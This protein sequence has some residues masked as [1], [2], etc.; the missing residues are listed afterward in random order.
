VFNYFPFA[1]GVISQL[2]NHE[3]RH[4]SVCFCQQA[5]FLCLSPYVPCFG[6][7]LLLGP[8]FLGSGNDSQ[9]LT[10]PMDGKL[11]VESLEHHSP[12]PNHTR[13]YG[14]SRL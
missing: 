1:Q 6:S 2:F 13:V 10:A 12:V 14:P 3:Q 8:G 5:A 4:L 9:R 7:Y 11:C